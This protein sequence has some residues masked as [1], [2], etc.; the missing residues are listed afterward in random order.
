MMVDGRLVPYGKP[1]HQIGKSPRERAEEAQVAFVI[2]YARER[3]RDK[4][5]VTL[6]SMLSTAEIAGYNHTEPR[7]HKNFAERRPDLWG[8][9]RN[10]IWDMAQNHESLVPLFKRLGCAFGNERFQFLP[11][12]ELLRRVD[13]LRREPA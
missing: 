3:D 9:M 4:F 8:L 12:P 2:A 11:V 5:D 7:R 6:L 1:F 13:E 10:E